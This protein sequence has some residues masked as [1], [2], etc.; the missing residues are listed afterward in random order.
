M[1]SGE[2]VEY[3]FRPSSNFDF[4]VSLRVMYALS[5]NFSSTQPFGISALPGVGFQM[6]ELF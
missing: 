3:Y 2:L 6:L 4:V 1:R 5:P